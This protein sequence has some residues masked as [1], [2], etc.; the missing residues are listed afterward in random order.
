MLGSRVFGLTPALTA[1]ELTASQWYW[2]VWMIRIYSVWRMQWPE[3][4]SRKLE[5]SDGWHRVAPGAN[6]ASETLLGRAGAGSLRSTHWTAWK[7]QCP[8]SCDRKL[9]R[10]PITDIS[11]FVSGMDFLDHQRRYSDG[12][13]ALRRGSLGTSGA[14]ALVLTWSH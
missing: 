11:S 7:P 9:V 2:H 5:F 10:C 14:L 3:N 4:V 13:I 8:M 6:L 12:L 1:R